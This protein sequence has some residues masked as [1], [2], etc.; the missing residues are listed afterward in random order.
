MT[1]QR[2]IGRPAALAAI[3]VLAG[4]AGVAAQ[5]RP[6]FEW[7][8]RVDREVRLVMRNRSLDTRQVSWT[9]RLRDRSRVFSVLPR[10][11]GQ[12]YVRVQEGR[13][14]V[15]VIEQP[16]RFNSYTAVIR[17]RDPRS[18]AD[19]Y[20]L[21]AFWRPDYNGRGRDR[22]DQ[23][24]WNRGNDQGGW[25]RGNRNDRG[26]RDDRGG[27]NRGD[28]RN[29]RGGWNRGDD[30]G[31]RGGYGMSHGVARFSGMV[32]DE[33]ELRIQ[34]RRIDVVN[35]RGDGTRDVRTNLSGEMPRA[36]VQLRVNNRDGRGRINVIQQP[37]A[38]NGYTAIV[39]VKDPQ[40]GY[41]RYDF[42]VTW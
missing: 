8:G 41:G 26:D 16:S 35:L 29:D 42:D 21:Q 6:L 11:D 2:S 31:D 7:R 20:R 17:I 34:G 22:D 15:D 37:S 25:N 12:V 19:N 24:G 40:S 1:L 28:D 36:D 39:R 13:G 14:D 38:W 23:G 4:A 33:M 18:G 3:L 32:D 30:R 27:W 10:E 5:E 9:E